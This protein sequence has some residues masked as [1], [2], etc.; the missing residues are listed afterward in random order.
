VKTSEHTHRA[1]LN[2]GLRPT[3]AESEPT[4]HVEAHLL[5]Y[6]GDLYDETLEVTFAE[7]IRAEQKF[8]D[9]DALKTQIAK[10]VESARRIFA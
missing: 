3:L 1:A 9:L 10:D 7:K 6:E 4:L 8:P 5:D 2:I